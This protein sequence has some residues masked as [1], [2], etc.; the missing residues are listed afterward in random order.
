[1]LNSNLKNLIIVL[2]LVFVFM[3]CGQ[4]EKLP[5]PSLSSLVIGSWVGIEKQMTSTF[6]Y[7]MSGGSTLTGVQEWTV[8]FYTK[9]EFDFIVSLAMSVDGKSIGVVKFVTKGSYEAFESS[10]AFRPDSIEMQVTPPE[11]KPVMDVA[12]KNQLEVF[13]NAFTGTMS[14][15]VSDNVLL[16][17][18][19]PGR[20]QKV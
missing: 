4:D 8:I 11:L 13:K 2:V 14:A 12:F 17:E 3:S 7:P 6:V 20:F 19:G 15:S 5:K 10:I 16:L 9:G 18:N 1:M